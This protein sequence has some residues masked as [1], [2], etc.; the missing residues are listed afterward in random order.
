M[1]ALRTG[2]KPFALEKTFL[3]DFGK[4]GAGMRNQSIIHDRIPFAAL[5]YRTASGDIVSGGIQ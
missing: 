3:F 1:R 2:Q 5:R 4:S